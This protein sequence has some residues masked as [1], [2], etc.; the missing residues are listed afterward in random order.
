MSGIREATA[1][2]AAAKVGSEGP[3][4]DPIAEALRALYRDTEA[5]PLPP[6]LQAL[7]ARLAADEEAGR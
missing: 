7:L 3:E 4:P 2:R 5:E 6:R 1:T